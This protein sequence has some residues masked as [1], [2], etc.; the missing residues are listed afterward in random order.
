[1]GLDFTVDKALHLVTQSLVFGEVVDV[2][3]GGAHVIKKCL[4]YI[5]MGYVKKM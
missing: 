1:M 2:V 4:G 5:Y 3:H